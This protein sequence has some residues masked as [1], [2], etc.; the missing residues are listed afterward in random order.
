MTAVYANGILNSVLNR[1]PSTESFRLPFWISARLEAMLSPSPLPSVCREL[2]PLT[3]LSISSSA[4]ML[5]CSLE[6]FFRDIRAFP[7]SFE[8]SMYTLV[9]ANAY[10]LMLL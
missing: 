4:L 2:S 1:S 3:N 5:S 6:M 7:S 9:L 10:L 8:T